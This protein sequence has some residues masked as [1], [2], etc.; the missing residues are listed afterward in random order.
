ML[1][2]SLLYIPIYVFYAGTQDS[3]TDIQEQLHQ[4]DSSSVESCLVAAIFHSDNK[5]K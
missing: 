4:A 1:E 2:Y 5:P 3:A